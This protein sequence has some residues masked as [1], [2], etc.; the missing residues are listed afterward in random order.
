MKSE[1]N[2]WT[3]FFRVSFQSEGNTVILVF[4]Y[5]SSCFFSES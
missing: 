5:Y 2:F 1:L 4:E 3:N